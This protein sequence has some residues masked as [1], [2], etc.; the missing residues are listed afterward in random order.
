MEFRP[1][2]L[3]T[4]GV[5]V[6]TGALLAFAPVVTTSSCSMTAPGASTCATTAKSLLATEGSGVLPLL[7][8]PSFLAAV[9]VLARGQKWALTS[10][11]LLSLAALLA[12]A[13]IGI[14]LLPTVVLAWLSTARAGDRDVRQRPAAPAA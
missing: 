12:I 6:A 8:V 2:P 4:L 5:A 13:S 14:Y 7:A 3:V 10:A 1:W 11:L 9:P